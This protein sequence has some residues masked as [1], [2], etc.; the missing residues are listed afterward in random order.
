MA[1]TLLMMNGKQL[2][3]GL[4]L[5]VMLN[6]HYHE[7]EFVAWLREQG[8][9]LTEANVSLRL[10]TGRKTGDPLTHGL[11]SIPKR[12]VSAVLSWMISEARLNGQQVTFAEPRP[13]S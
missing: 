1:E 6:G 11:V 9:D 5:E 10:I 2:E 3:K 12:V 7:N 4:L 8:L 13:K